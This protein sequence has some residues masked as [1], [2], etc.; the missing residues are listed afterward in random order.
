MKLS[1]ENDLQKKKW[2]W[3]NN[4]W[5]QNKLIFSIWN[6]Y[7]K[8][9]YFAD[10]GKQAFGLLR[11]SLGSVIE[12]VF[13]AV[14]PENPVNIEKYRKVKKSSRKIKPEEDWYIIPVPPIID[15][16][17]FK[18]AN[19]QLQENFKNCQRNKKN[20]YLLGN[21]IYCTCGH[22]RNGEGVKNGQNLYY[23]CSSR[24]HSFPLK[25]TCVEKG[26]NARIADKLIFDKIAEIMSSPELM[27]K[28]AERWLN[29]KNTKQENDILDIPNIEKQIKKLKEEEDRYNKAYGAGV[30]DIDKLKEYTTN[31]KQQVLDLRSK[32]NTYNEEIKEIPFNLP[33]PDEILAYSI[34]ATEMLKGL[35]FAQ[36][37]DIILNIVEKVTGNQEKL[38]VTGYLPIKSSSNYEY[39]SIHRHCRPSKR[40]Q[41]NII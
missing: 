28:Q 13:Y 9:Y 12:G 2:Y 5:I 6:R 20:E 23:R 19:L 38:T 15:E 3:K 8:A 1:I 21:R 25:T 31:I 29:S 40:R 33:K 30:M 4:L 24:V 26:I 11:G 27:E 39:K 7:F 32:I 41:I 22:R 34:E 14:V 10:N 16:G 17:V 18:R 36:K 35:D 37:R